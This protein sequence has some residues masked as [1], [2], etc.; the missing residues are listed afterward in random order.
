[1]RATLYRLAVVEPVARG[2]DAALELAGHALDTVADTAERV[3]ELARW[4]ASASRLV[5]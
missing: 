5:P 2:L 1:M 4:A 3:A